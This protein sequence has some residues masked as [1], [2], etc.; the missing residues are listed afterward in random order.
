MKTVSML[1]TIVTCI[2]MLGIPALAGN[3][4]SEAHTIVDSTPFITANPGETITAKILDSEPVSKISSNG[5]D[6]FVL[7]VTQISADGSTGP[8]KKLYI[9]KIIKNLTSQL[10]AIGK[11]HDGNLENVIIDLTYGTS[12]K[13]QTVI[14]KMV[15]NTTATT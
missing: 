7:N 4:M 5:N 9:V 15:E 6:M 14:T 1:V 3:W 10:L 12:T 2:A 13:G 11:A 8:Q